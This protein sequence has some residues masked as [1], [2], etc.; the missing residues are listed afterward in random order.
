MRNWRER[1][2]DEPPQNKSMIQFQLEKKLYD[3]MQVETQKAQEKAQKR[4]Q[5]LLAE[6]ARSQAY[7]DSLNERKEQEKRELELTRTMTMR[8]KF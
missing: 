5:R 1:G 7:F 3:V 4:E 6:Q 8:P 2:L